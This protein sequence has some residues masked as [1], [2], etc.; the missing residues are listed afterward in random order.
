MAAAAVEEWDSDPEKRLKQRVR[1][2][3]ARLSLLGLVV[4]STLGRQKQ[5]LELAPTRKRPRAPEEENEDVDS[6]APLHSLVCAMPW[7]DD[8][9]V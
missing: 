4:S 7:S 3:V 8:F 6:D 5:Q 1:V 2:T 9:A